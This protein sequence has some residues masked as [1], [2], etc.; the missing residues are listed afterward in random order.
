MPAEPFSVFWRGAVRA[1]IQRLEKQIKNMMRDQFEQEFTKRYSRRPPGSVR[2]FLGGFLCCAVLA[3]ALWAALHTFAGKEAAIRQLIRKNYLED[4]SAEEITEGKYRGMVAATGDKYAAYYTRE[5]YADMKKTNKGVYTGIG[6]T[7]STDAE[8]GEVMIVDVF[9]ASPADRAGLLAGDRVLE[10]N[11]VKPPDIDIS[12]IAAGLRSGELKFVTITVEREGEAEPITVTLEPEE[13]DLRTVAYELKE[14]GTGYIAVSNFRETTATHFE[15]ALKDLKEKGMQRLV[16]DLRG[17]TGGLVSATTQML[18]TFIPEGLLVYTVDKAGNRKEY[19]SSCKEP[20]EVPLAVLVNQNSASASEIFA[21]AV[22]DRK[23]GVIV[24]Q[25]TYGKG[26]VQSFLPLFDNSA[27]KI[28]TAYYY[29]PDGVNINGTG[30]T[31]DLEVEMEE[32]GVMD[33]GETDTQY[34]AAVAELLKESSP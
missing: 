31:P 18:G 32:D 30:I 23:A 15:S 1:R 14:D 21:G 33:T 5:E 3:A 8:T 26:I 7:F 10:M 11:G 9:E 24:G 2:A 13:V 19:K 12:E 28:T 29:T 25:T 27:V 20:L 16:I 34:Q 22:K 17:N 6:I 4:I